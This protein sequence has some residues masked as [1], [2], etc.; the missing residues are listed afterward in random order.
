MHPHHTQ[1]SFRRAYL[2]HLLMRPSWRSNSLLNIRGFTV[3][4]EVKMDTLVQVRRRRTNMVNLKSMILS[5]GLISCLLCGIADAS[6]PGQVPDLLKRDSNTTSTFPM[7]YIGPRLLDCGAPLVQDACS[8]YP[9][10]YTMTTGQQYFLIQAS[11]LYS[12]NTT[13]SIVAHNP[14]ITIPVETWM[15]LSG[16]YLSTVTHG[17]PATR[18]AVNTAYTPS[19]ENAPLTIQ[20]PQITTPPN[21]PR[22]MMPV[23]RAL[24]YNVCDEKPP[25][26]RVLT[27]SL[28]DV[29]HFVANAKSYFVS[30]RPST[31]AAYL[32][33]WPGY[34]VQSIFCGMYFF[35]IV[36][37]PKF[38]A[39]AN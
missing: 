20:Q 12:I 27:R 13:Y 14:T 11:Y 3:L 7:I 21:I 8:F 22:N 4:T 39:M 23:K 31:D 15:V 16:T 24:D 25:Y 35:C 32:P 37:P 9:L 10:N 26:W 1:I 17:P 28:V 36:R 2:S 33:S 19:L 5:G 29:C 30:L 34:I 6:K 38:L 18:V